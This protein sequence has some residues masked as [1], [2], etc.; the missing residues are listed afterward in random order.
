MHTTISK[1][2]TGRPGHFDIYDSYLLRPETLLT[3]DRLTFNIL[4]MSA[5]FIIISK[6]SG[7]NDT[8]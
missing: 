5:Q 2:R 8:M 3:V 4:A 6:Y 1:R 7:A